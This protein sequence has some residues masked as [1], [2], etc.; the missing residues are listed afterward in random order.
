MTRQWRR[1]FPS[2]C[3]C[4][5]SA[6]QQRL[7]CPI[8]HPCTFT[9]KKRY[10]KNKKRSKRPRAQA[11]APRPF[12]G[13]FLICF[14]KARSAAPV[15]LAATTLFDPVF[16]LKNRPFER[17]ISLLTVLCFIISIFSIFAM[18]TYLAPVFFFLKRIR[19]V[20][21]AYQPFRNPNYHCTNSRT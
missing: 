4:C 19:K 10:K 17:F 5:P 6:A 11:E 8:P 13:I 2:F 7:R 12:Y 18:L 20:A 9:G 1:P 14:R 3:G 16:P 15:F 21:F